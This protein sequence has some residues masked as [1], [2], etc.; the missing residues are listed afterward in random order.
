M[1]VS[2]LGPMRA[3]FVRRR[4][5]QAA[6]LT[7]VLTTLGVGAYYIVQCIVVLV[8][9]SS[10]VGNHN[11]IANSAKNGRGD[12]VSVSTEA[13]GRWHDPDPTV[14]QLRQAYHWLWTT[15]VK[16][17]SFGV[18]EDL[19]WV[20]DDTLDV[21]LGFGCLVHM[22]RP[23]AAIGSIRISYRFSNGDKTLSKGCSD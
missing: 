1:A 8:L 5:A 9:F 10:V 22:T 3:A 16:A 15:L 20:N 13:S 6:L 19:K 11:I 21:T 23:V 14:V 4:L 12:E 2:G 7:A 17:R 18:R